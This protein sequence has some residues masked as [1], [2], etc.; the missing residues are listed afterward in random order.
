[1]LKYICRNTEAGFPAS[2]LFWGLCVIGYGKDESMRK[3]E[4]IHK[5]W[6]RRVGVL[7]LAAA[8]GLGMPFASVT[9]VPFVRDTAMTAY[10]AEDMLGYEN[11]E[12]IVIAMPNSNNYSTT[13]S[14]IS[15]L[16]ACDY[17]YPLTMNGEPVETTE[18]GFFT[19][20]V[21]LSVGENEFLFENGDHE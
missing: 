21:T 5:R 13:A 14:K 20:Y 4:I 15:I 9:G 1:M 6:G 11:P 7:T 8:L 3:Y 19:T 16:G 12:R 18:Y 10:A 17:R 2:V